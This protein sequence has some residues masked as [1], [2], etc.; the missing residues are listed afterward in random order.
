M[1]VCYSMGDEEVEEEEEKVNVDMLIEY[2]LIEYK[3]RRK[4]RR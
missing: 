4:R 2:M 1:S 3:R